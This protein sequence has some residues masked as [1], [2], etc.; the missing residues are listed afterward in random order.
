MST[1]FLREI[2]GPMGALEA[3]LDLPPG[4]PRAAVVFAHSHP[5]QGG[6]MHSKAVYQSAKAL[7]RIG[8]AVL[9]FNFRGVGLSAGSFDA[10][11]GEV[12]DYRAGL[13]YMAGRFPGLPLWAAGISFGAWIALPAGALDPRVTVLIG[14]SAPVDRY[15][16]T[17]LETSTKP[18]FFVHG[19]MD[20]LISIKDMRRFYARVPEPKELIEIDS[21]SHLFDGKA[22]EVGE[23]L[24]G[25]LAGFEPTDVAG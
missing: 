17:A 18:K 23:A 3:L 8:C 25:L 4:E 19:E 9:R 12:D 10:G 20:E 1:E 11:L 13:D 21:G 14:V 24:E 6:T 5:Q 16:L 7:A 15:D 22:S 2:P